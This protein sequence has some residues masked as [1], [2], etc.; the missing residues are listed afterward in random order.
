[1]IGFLIVDLDRRG[2]GHRQRAHYGTP[3]LPK[4][5]VDDE[6]HLRGSSY[7]ATRQ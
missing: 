1:M 4:D 2:A 6:A 3:R 7:L 5:V